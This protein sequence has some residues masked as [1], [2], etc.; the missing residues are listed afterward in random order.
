M[1]NTPLRK[2]RPK[3]DLVTVKILRE[4]VRN[5]KKWALDREMKFYEVVNKLINK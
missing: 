5:I 4:D 3:A 1:I 2:K